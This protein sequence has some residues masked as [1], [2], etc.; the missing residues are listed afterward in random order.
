MNLTLSGLAVDPVNII[1]D[2][3]VSVMGL[4]AKQNRY[5]SLRECFVFRRLRRRTPGYF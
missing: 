3:P 1:D 4:K 2:Y 5:E